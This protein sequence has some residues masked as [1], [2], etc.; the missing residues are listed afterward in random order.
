MIILTVKRNLTWSIPE[1]KRWWWTEETLQ[2]L[3]SIDPGASVQ[4]TKV[5]REPILITDKWRRNFFSALRADWSPLHASMLLPSAPCPPTSNI[6]RR[7]C[8]DARKWI[9][10]HSP[11][12][13]TKHTYS[14]WVTTSSNIIRTFQFFEYPLA[15]AVN[16]SASME[17]T[18]YTPRNSSLTS[19][20]SDTHRK[21]ITDCSLLETSVVSSIIIVINGDC[22]KQLA[23]SLSTCIAM[24]LRMS[25]WF[26]VRCTYLWSWIILSFEFEK[27]EKVSILFVSITSER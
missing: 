18:W 7:L 27:L 10:T 20:S 6:F 5:P 26:D 12:S 21:M 2:P 24:I 16:V 22:C 17:G 14:R 19:K 25:F 3:Y 23:T 1:K 4:S 15:A 13:W 11:S 8:Y 9:G